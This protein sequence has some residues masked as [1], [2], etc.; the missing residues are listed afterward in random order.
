MKK[1]IFSI[2]LSMTILF[3]SA[4]QIDNFKVGNVN[5]CTAYGTEKVLQDQAYTNGGT[6][7]TFRSFQNEYESAQIVMTPDYDVRS[8]DIAISDLYCGDEVLEK[9]NF[10]VFH[11]KYLEVE[12]DYERF[13]EL[14]TGW[15]PEALLPMETAIRYDENKIQKG[16]NQG[17][18]VCLY[19]PEDQPAGTYTGNFTVTID[20]VKK[21]IPV[22]VTVWGYAISTENHTKSSYAV[23]IDALRYGESNA[24][25]DMEK[26]YVDNLLDFRLSPQSLPNGKGSVLTWTKDEVEK[27]LDLAVEYALNE[28]CSYINMPVSVVEK[29][30][31]GMTIKTADEALYKDTLRMIAERSI[32]ENLNIFK[33]MDMYLLFVDEAEMYGGAMV[34]G[35]EYSTEMMQVYQ[36]EVAEELKEK[37]SNGT[38]LP[39][40]DYAEDFAYEVLEE[41]RTLQQI[42]TGAPDVIEEIEGGLSFDHPTTFC[43]VIDY[44][45]DPV[46]VEYYKDYWAWYKEYYD[47]ENVEQ[48]LYTAVGPHAPFTNLHMDSYYFDQR[49]LGWLMSEHDVAGHLYWY[50]NLYYDMQ[51]W[52]SNSV[53][54]QNCYKEAERFPWVNGDGFL[55]YPGLP[56]GIEGPVNSTRIYTV[57]DSMEDYEVLYLIEQEYKKI[58]KEE[59][60]EYDRTQFESLVRALTSDFY[61]N[62]F[63]KS[64]P[65]MVD[66]FNAMREMLFKVLEMITK[67]GTYVTEFTAGESVNTLK[68]SAP[69]GTTFTQDG[70]ALNGVN[71]G[72]KV[73]AEVSV[74]LE[75]KDYTSFTV[76][77]D[78]VNVALNWGTG[79]KYQTVTSNALSTKV[80]VENGTGALDANGAIGEMY[81][82][83]LPTNTSAGSVVRQIDLDLSSYNLDDATKWFKLK[84]YNYGEKV[85]LEVKV[86]N[87]DTPNVFRNFDQVFSSETTNYKMTLNPGWNTV[88]LNIYGML[89]YKPTSGAYEDKHGKITT[90]RLIATDDANV[91]IGF[92]KWL[93]EE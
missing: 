19:T 26:R 46:F 49:A 50:T 8:Y 17:I 29:N 45:T 89:F 91:S 53:P 61:K 25:V 75:E 88:E 39:E 66:D 40:V 73:F 38:W 47:A 83:T 57:R 87:E 48:W 79:T 90:L 28:K 44:M 6:T 27:W 69:K 23:Y 24:T 31:D 60:R 16:N 62:S 21:T 78:G 36:Q 14:S 74:N 82:V 70:S 15:Y 33:K 84:I 86:T 35:M 71:V 72:E 85:T 59:G 77:K 7:L 5:V 30:V 1:R 65:R 9:E 93:F 13:N 37:I 11:Q 52:N 51:G 68:L 58:A 43:S 32:Q 63:I 67:T 12:T 54:L 55:T 3:A 76:T 41:M 2:A 34:K 92:G 22:E 20:G 56:Y 18:W 81:K 4:C 80:R 64:E 42:A 10:E